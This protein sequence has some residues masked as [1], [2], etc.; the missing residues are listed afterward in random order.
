MLLALSLI[1]ELL[2]LYRTAISNVQ[3]VLAKLE[4][5]FLEIAIL[6]VFGQHICRCAIRQ[7]RVQIFQIV[8][9]RDFHCHDCFLFLLATCEAFAIR[10]T[11]LAA[12]LQQLDRFDCRVALILRND[13]HIQE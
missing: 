13:I 12:V 9:I 11:Q 5:R 4:M 1:P 3:R 8:K 10:H 6:Q 7:A 2:F